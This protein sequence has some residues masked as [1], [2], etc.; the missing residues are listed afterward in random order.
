VAA[1]VLLSPNLFFGFADALAAKAM[2]RA[3]AVVPASMFL[4]I[5]TS[6]SEYSEKLVKIR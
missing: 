1:A 3:R 5:V 6:F 2:T 4:S